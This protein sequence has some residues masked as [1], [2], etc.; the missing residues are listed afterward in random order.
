[1]VIAAVTALGAW[2][3]LPPAR[4]RGGIRLDLPGAMLVT[5]GV[6]AV[7]YGCSRASEAGWTAV[8]VLA[9]LAAG[10]ALLGAFAW[11]EAHVDQPL[12]PLGILRDRNRAGA[13]VAVGFAVAGMLG[14]FL[15]LSYYFQ[16][17]LGYSPI[18]SG[19]AFL[20]LSAAVLAS[21]Q[22]LAARL[23]PYVGPRALIVPGLVAA[24][25]AMVWLT[26]L[27]AAGGYLGHV[28]PAE[29]VLGLGLGCVF[30][31]AF[32]TATARVAPQHA[33]VAAAV[34]NAAQQVGGSV[35]LAVLNTV[36]TATLGHGHGHGAVAPAALVHGYT[37]AAAWGA[38]IFA[39]A[40]LIAAKL[41][42]AR[43]HTIPTEEHQ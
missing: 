28:L 39:A 8:A 6:A 25:G 19:L 34:V 18:V 40:A 5:A 10:A 11:R 13:Y 32:S 1:M 9:P 14:L 20:P 31:P 37:R 29:I 42:N 12:L 21:S 23:L 2:R 3:L 33:G 43:P 36:A 16:V 24:A 38:A 17:V 22:A 7:V 27:T 41:I 26:R 35:G 4:G 30:V 15:F